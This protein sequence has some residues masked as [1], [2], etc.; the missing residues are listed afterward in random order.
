MR[1]L[2]GIERNPKYYEQQ[3]SKMEYHD[4]AR[5]KSPF[6]EVDQN[7]IV[8]LLLGPCKFQGRFSRE[9]IERVI[10]ILDINVFEARTGMGHP[11][12]CLYPVFGVVAHSCVPNTAH[13]IK[14]CDGFRCVFFYDEVFSCKLIEF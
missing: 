12:R 4:E 8:N 10:G 9:L 7:N 14:V 11:V 1:L 2:L 6:W 13:S 5:R 3:I